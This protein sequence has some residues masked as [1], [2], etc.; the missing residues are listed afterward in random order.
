MCNFNLPVLTLKK[1]LLRIGKNSRATFIIKILFLIRGG[2][3]YTVLFV[4]L[5]RIQAGTYWP[6]VFHIAH[7]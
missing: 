2:N 4:T 5:L 6:Q 7:F 3:Y 1:L